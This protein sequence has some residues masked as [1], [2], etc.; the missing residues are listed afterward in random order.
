MPGEAD[1][2][3]GQTLPDGHAGEVVGP[4]GRPCFKPDIAA[5]LLGISERQVRNLA[6]TKLP[7]DPVPIG[8]RQRTFFLSAGVEEEAKRRCRPWPPAQP[9]LEPMSD[10]G[11][12]QELAIRQG[13]DLEEARALVRQRE[14]DLH[15]AQLELRSTKNDLKR[16]EADHRELNTAFQALS[17]LVNRHIAE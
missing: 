5:E 6:G 7:I 16:L 9:S 1:L 12:L 11:A 2:T 10:D 14:S 3:Y 8:H 17:A 4:S 13:R 15:E